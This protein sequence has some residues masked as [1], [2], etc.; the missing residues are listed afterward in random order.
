MNR[1]T[2]LALLLAVI[3]LTAGCATITT[4]TSQ[5]I[6]VDTKPT[7]ADC[8]FSR[9]GATIAFI[10]STPGNVTVSK[11]D[12]QLDIVCRK[13]GYQDGVGD[14]T[15]TFQAMTVGNVLIGGIVGLIVDAASGAATKYPSSVTITLTPESFASTAERDAFFDTMRSDF[16]AEYETSL[17]E[18]KVRCKQEY[19]CEEQLAN[20][21]AARESSLAESERQRSTAKIDVA[22]AAAS[23]TA[24]VST[25]EK[26]EAPQTV[27]TDGAFHAEEYLN[28]RSLFSDEQ[29]AEAV[30][31]A[32]ASM[33][34]ASSSREPEPSVPDR[35]RVAILPFATSSDTAIGYAEI[36]DVSHDYVNRQAGLELVYSTHGN[37]RHDRL[38]DTGALWSG[39]FGEQRPNEANVYRLAERIPADL[40]LM[41]FYRKRVAGWYSSEL[42]LFDIYLIDV[43]RRQIHHGSGDELSLKNITKSVF[44]NIPAETSI[45]RETAPTPPGR[46]RV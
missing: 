22:I 27:Y 19:S 13:E 30:S 41:Y 26:L 35:I 16:L 36:V 43:R 39:G 37:D 29:A 20:A 32:S 5:T 10:G 38:G 44:A 33:P 9:E 6:E 11:D 23:S 1:K 8:E 17:E 31:P 12:S 4:G 40:A 2:V 21:Q 45:S 46:N 7:G 28:T 3:G 18:I 34:G 15:S 14:L 42:Y 25:A 24:P